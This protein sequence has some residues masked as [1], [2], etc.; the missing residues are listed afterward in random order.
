MGPDKIH[1]KVLKQCA[2]VIPFPLQI[3]RNPEEWK[4]ALVVP[5]HEKGPKQTFKINVLY[6]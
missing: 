4:M 6:L 5:V 2:S 3:W 1:G